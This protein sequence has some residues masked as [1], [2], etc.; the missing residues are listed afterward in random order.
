MS[1]SRSSSSR[2]SSKVTDEQINELVSKLQ[3]F[4]PEERIPSAARVSAAEVL[5]EICTYVKSLHREVDYLSGKLSE[6]LETME[7]GS[8]EAAI[9]R[10]LLLQ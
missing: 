5:Q 3:A 8:E 10:S 6:L 4:L 2:Q 7:T 9:I 1:S